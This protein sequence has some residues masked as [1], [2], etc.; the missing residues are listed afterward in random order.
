MDK[1]RKLLIVVFFICMTGCANYKYNRAVAERNVITRA[2][3]DNKPVKE[4]T[5]FIEYV[6]VTGLFFVLVFQIKKLG[7]E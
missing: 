2:W 4:K 3:I 6:A 7:P 5:H 1:L